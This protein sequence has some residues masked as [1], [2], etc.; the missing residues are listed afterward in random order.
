[1]ALS[2]SARKQGNFVALDSVAFPAKKP[3]LVYLCAVETAVLVVRQVFTNQD[4]SEGVLYLVSSDTSLDYMHL[5]TIYQRRW[6]VE[7]YH[8]SLKQ[9]TGIGH[10]PT[11]TP[12]T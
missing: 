5:T 10:S 4:G 12:A 1:M 9:N 8:K 2:E 11:R 7:E 3:L 6:K